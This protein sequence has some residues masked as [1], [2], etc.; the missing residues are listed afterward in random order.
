MKNDEGFRLIGNSA[1]VF[2]GSRGVGRAVCIRL[3]NAGANV[4]FAFHPAE[5]EQE[6]A[7]TSAGI[8]AEGRRAVPVKCDIGNAEAVKE[9]FKIASEALGPI[10]MVVNT[11]G[12][13]APIKPVADL[14]SKEWT[15]YIT[16][17]LNGAF[18]IV[19]HAVNHLRLAGGGAIVALSSIASRTV[20]FGNSTGAAAKAGVEALIRVVAREEG[21]HA[22]RANVI[23]IGVTDTDMARATLSAW[24]EATANKMIGAIPLGRIGTPDDVAKMAQFLLSHNATYITG[25]VFQVDGGQFIG[26]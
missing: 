3:A 21:R 14:T 19:H 17:D 15:D 20:P 11:A 7:E 25:K 10:C 9:A 24:G 18:N 26:G 1:V 2:G 5:C 23:G 13:I 8:L 22:I 12:S 6:A 4:A 16:V